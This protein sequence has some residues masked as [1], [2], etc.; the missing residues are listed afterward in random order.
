MKEKILNGLD[1]TGIL[2][3]AMNIKSWFPGLSYFLIHKHCNELVSEGK[4]TKMKCSGIWIYR[5]KKR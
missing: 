3:S 4:I 5:I 1:E 2:T